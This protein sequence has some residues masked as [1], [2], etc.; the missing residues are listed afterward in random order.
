MSRSVELSYDA[1]ITASVDE[2]IVETPGGQFIF[3]FLCQFL[4]DRTPILFE[5]T[6]TLIL[7][8]MSAYIYHD[9]NV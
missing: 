9:S 2:R 7:E 8:I 5:K 1:T 3:I 6:F 4:K